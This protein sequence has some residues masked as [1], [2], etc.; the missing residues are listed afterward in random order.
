MWPALDEWTVKLNNVCLHLALRELLLEQACDETND[1]NLVHLTQPH[2]RHPASELGLGVSASHKAS[3]DILVHVCVQTHV[4]KI[5]GFETFSWTFHAREFE[6]Q[7]HR[8]LKMWQC[9]ILVGI[10]SITLGCP[11]QNPLL[12]E[13]H[14]HFARKSCERIFKLTSSKTTREHWRED[15]QSSEEATGTS[16]TEAV[17][18]AGESPQGWKKPKINYVLV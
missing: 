8:G 9:I 14:L 6:F 2:F 16:E 12:Q 15:S 11:L 3:G 5:P 10:A 1:V 7:F 13:R 4:M 17:C 18:S